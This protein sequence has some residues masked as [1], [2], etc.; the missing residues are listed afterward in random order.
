M[1]TTSPTQGAAPD[2]WHHYGRTRGD[3]DRSVPEEFS[4]IW[5]QDS[6]P[7]AEM[8]GDLTGLLVADLGAGAAR[9]AAHLATHH[10]PARVDAVDASPAQHAM[11]SALYGHLAPRLRTVH[12]D[13][14]EHLNERPGGYNVLYSVFGAVDFTDPRLL[15]PAAA[16]ALHPGGMFAAA[17]LGH[18]IGGAPAEPDV[19]HADVPARAPDGTPTTMRR[20]VLQEHV[21]TKLLDSAGFT[22]ITI[23]RLP[24]A[25][26]GPR[27]ADTLLLRA[28]R[29]G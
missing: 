20:W 13:V 26:P 8:L 14:A 16:R 17:T 29:S 9:H 25:T 18:Y 11:A 22:E 23:D 3:T 5:A 7:G 2:L 1:K 6:G 28:Y 21:W 24:P 4:W 15:L 12:A 19:Q 10:A 27:S